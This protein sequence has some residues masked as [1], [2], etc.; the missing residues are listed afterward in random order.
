MC[1]TSNRARSNKHAP[2]IETF[3]IC[4][5]RYLGKI[6]Y[7]AAARVTAGI[8]HAGSYSM[9]AALIKAHQLAACHRKRHAKI[10]NLMIPWKPVPER[11]RLGAAQTAS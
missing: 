5:R 7:G 6:P 3:G 4:S 9:T 8:C 1:V 11:A 10:S 2:C